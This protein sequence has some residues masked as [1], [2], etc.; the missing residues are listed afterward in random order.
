MATKHFKY[1]R[2]L[3]EFTEG[4]VFEHPWEVTVTE[5][6]AALFQAS[7]LDATRIFSSTAYARGLG[8]RDR[9]VHPLLLLNLGLGFSVQDVSECAIAQ[10]AY[11]DVRFPSA[12]HVGDT[13]TASTRVLGTK[14]ASSGDRGVVHVATTVSTERGNPVCAFE[15]KVLVPAKAR[16]DDRSTS[17]AWRSP[18]TKEPGSTPSG[19][20]PLARLPVELRGPRS[21]A[22]PRAVFGAFAEDFNVGDLLI[23]DTGRTVAEAEQMQ[24]AYLCRNSHPGHSDEL[25]CRAGGNFALTRVVYGGLVFA[26]VVALASRD[27]SSNVVWDLGYDNGAHPQSV[28]A[29]DTI[30]AASKVLAKE[31]HD[32]LA[33]EVV[34]RVIGTKNLHPARA[35]ERGD[36][37]FG[38][39][40]AK[41]AAARIQEKVFEIDR[42]V[43]MLKRPDAGR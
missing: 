23:H 17:A 35:L 34:F 43:L 20:A 10:L 30:Y 32:D 16:D 25:Y 38:A 37:L 24:L 3:G 1:G 39:E 18:T 36:D 5:G 7:F 21:V 29:G 13:L 4:E 28:V 42:R 31:P 11:L 12:A 26:W 19:A 6:T 41:P 9:P 15:R 40:L 14:V 33:D 8:F 2:I 27:T 22:L